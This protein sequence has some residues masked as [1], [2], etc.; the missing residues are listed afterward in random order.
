MAKQDPNTGTWK[1]EYSGRERVRLVVETLDDPATVSDIAERADV[2]WG[3]ADS[4]LE[5]LLA[6]KKVQEHTVDGET[7]YG[8]N[9]VQMLVEEVLNLIS[10]H[11]RNELESAL[12][13]YTSQLESLEDE[14]EVRSLS[15]LRDELA[16]EELSSEEIQE[17]RNVTSTWEAL[18]TEIRITK[19]ALQLYDDVARLSDSNGD[20]LAIA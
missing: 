17:I 8:P 20:E 3:T 13:E 12:V 11:S 2:A 6:E 18:L 7:K 14:Y 9:P 15:E 1:E 4:E 19:H 16:T 10:E 5:N